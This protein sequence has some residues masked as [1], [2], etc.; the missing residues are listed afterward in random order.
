MSAGIV[1]LFSAHRINSA[2]IFV[3]FSMFCA[4]VLFSL[5]SFFSETKSPSAGAVSPAPE[6]NG[7]WDKECKAVGRADRNATHHV[8]EARAVTGA[9]SL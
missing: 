4:L 6:W 2:S 5:L 8:A 9:A 3:Q 1:A 7:N